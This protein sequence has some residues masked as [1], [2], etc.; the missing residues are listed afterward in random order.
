MIADG[1]IRSLDALIQELINAA[2]ESAKR[3]GSVWNMSNT[4]AIYRG[5]S[6]IW[7]FI[8]GKFPGLAEIY[9]ELRPFAICNLAK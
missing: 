8:K 7:K 1:N 5:Q 3:G 9:D 2:Y 6:A 4:I